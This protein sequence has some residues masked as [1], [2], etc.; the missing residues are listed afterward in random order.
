MGQAKLLKALGVLDIGA[1]K[2]TVGSII[3][4][5]R[6]SALILKNK[7]KKLAKRPKMCT[8]SN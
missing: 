8:I 3:G 7:K 1:E 5:T 6:P 4:G 2:V